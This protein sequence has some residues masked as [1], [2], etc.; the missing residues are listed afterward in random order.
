MIVSTRRNRIYYTV[1][2]TDQYWISYSKKY[3]EYNSYIQCLKD[4]ITELKRIA[5]DNSPFKELL[6][7]N[8]EFFQILISWLKCIRY[9]LYFLRIVFT[10]C[11]IDKFKIQ[12]KLPSKIEQYQTL[13]N[14]PER[15]EDG[16]F[17]HQSDGSYYA[18]I[19]QEFIKCY[20]AEKPKF[21]ETLDTLLKANINRAITKLEKET[22]GKD[23]LTVKDI[24]CNPSNQSV[25]RIFSRVKWLV[26]GHGKNMLFWF[27][28]KLKTDLI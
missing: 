9:I 10:E 3:V 18:D 26:D 25:E 7:E 8:F 22:S 13:R 1:Y 21:Q 11:L 23:R 12:I 2:L 17:F 19:S 16:T 6:E 15:R 14:I 28:I 27:K 24:F 5:S 4:I 20:Q